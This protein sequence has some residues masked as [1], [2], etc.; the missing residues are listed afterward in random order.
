M[1][2]KS[3]LLLMLG[4]NDDLVHHYLIDDA[5]YNEDEEAPLV[6]EVYDSHSITVTFNTE[7]SGSNFVVKR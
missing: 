6:V 2:K 4:W 7:T 5:D 3:D 1:A